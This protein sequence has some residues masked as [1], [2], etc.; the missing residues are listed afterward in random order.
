MKKSPVITLLTDFGLQDEYVG[1]MKGAILSIN[2][3]V[4]LVDIT[5]NVSRHD[6]RQAALVLN[7][8]FRFFP[9]SSIHLVVVDPGVGGERRIICLEQ[10]G[11][12]FLAPDNGVLTM[13]IQDKRVRK[14]CAV[15]KRK[16][17]LEPVSDTFHGRDVFAPVAAHLS[18]GLEMLSL[19]KELGLKDLTRLDIPVPL[20]SDKHELVGAV[21]AIDRFG[22]LVTNISERTLKKFQDDEGSQRVEVRLGRFK[23]KGVAKSYDSVKVGAPMAIVG[24]RNLLEIALNQGDA[25]KYFKA[26]IGQA[27]KVRF[28]AR[29]K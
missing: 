5:H 4:Q 20:V 16:Y 6:I 7:A 11:H 21:M 3:R 1:V 18:K 22:S 28:V 17:F 26:R 2:P 13:V 12:F 19:G 8:S 10:E 29:G 24:S 25:R 23:I 14:I 27:V 15:T 9:K